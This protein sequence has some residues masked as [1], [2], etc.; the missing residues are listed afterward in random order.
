MILTEYIRQEN[1]QANPIVELQA[2]ECIYEMTI[3]DRSYYRIPLLS[4][5]FGI[6]QSYIRIGDDRRLYTA[7]SDTGELRPSA[8]YLSR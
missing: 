8:F 3:G 2:T 4:E 5:H 7:H 6:T 1:P